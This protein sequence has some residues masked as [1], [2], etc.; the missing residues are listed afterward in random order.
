[1]GRV[2]MTDP[3]KWRPGVGIS[4]QSVVRLALHFQR[5][6]DLMGEAWF[7]GNNRRMYPELAGDL[8]AI[9][10]SGLQDAFEQI[11]SGTSSFGNLPE[12]NEWYHFLM[13][14]L[15]HRHAEASVAALNEY[16]I[17]AF[18]VLHPEG[19]N[20]EP[21]RGFRDDCFATL[22]QCMMDGTFWCNGQIQVGTCLHR[23]NNNPAKY[24]GWDTASGDFSASAF[25]CAKY[26]RP[27]EIEPWLDS[28]LTI[29]SAHWVAQIMVWLLGAH[30]VFSGAILQPSQFGE[31][32]D[33]SWAWSHVIRG[34]YHDGISTRTIDFVPRA[35][36]DEILRVLVGHLSPE[37]F[38]GWLDLIKRYPYLEA[39]LAELPSQFA[40]VYNIEL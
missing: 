15:I 39:E 29:Q 14:R 1:M 4:K 27:A 37:L 28:I 19:I 8:A 31:R 36:R 26:L 20:D 30:E 38:F 3:F 12:W 24:W 5:P 13:P 18:F 33:V 17:G 6:R 10:I 22:G 21:Y 23:S 11:Y 2:A 7:M 9:D 35:N 40:Q 16:L 25:F 32:P 34:D